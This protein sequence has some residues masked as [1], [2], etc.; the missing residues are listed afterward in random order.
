VG[1]AARMRKWLVEDQPN[2]LTR[3]KMVRAEE[4]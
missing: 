3:V 2:N 1:D 4:G